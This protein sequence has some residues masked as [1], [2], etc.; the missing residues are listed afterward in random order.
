ME[1]DIENAPVDD[2]IKVIDRHEALNGV[3]GTVVIEPLK[4][5]DLDTFF[6]VSGS[7]ISSTISDALAN[8][9]GLK[10]SLVLKVE[11]V[12]TNPATRERIPT[13]SPTLDQPSKLSPN[14]QTWSWRSHS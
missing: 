3:F 13:S 14:Q 7:T 5:H 10:V 12:K 4:P 2:E 6:K 1:K 11:L 9:K 8:K